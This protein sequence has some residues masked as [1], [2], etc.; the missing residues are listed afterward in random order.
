MAATGTRSAGRESA[1]GVSTPRRDS[2][3][4][5]RGT[6]RFAG[7]LNVPGLKP[8]SKGD[9]DS[10]LA[11]ATY[12]GFQVLALFSRCLKYSNASGISDNTM[13]PRMTHV[14]FCL[15]KGTLPNQYPA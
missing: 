12:G 3:R 13:M 1:I 7:D 8:G 11:K 4:K 2:E 15:T 14:R 10:D 6:T 5:V 9:Y